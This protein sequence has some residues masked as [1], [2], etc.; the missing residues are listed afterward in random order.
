MKTAENA[1]TRAAFETPRVCVTDILMNESI[2][3]DC[4]YSEIRTP[5]YTEKNVLNGGTINSYSYYQVYSQILRF[6]EGLA[7]APTT[8]YLYFEPTTVCNNNAAWVSNGQYYK[9]YDVASVGQNPDRTL[10]SLYILEDGQ[11]SNLPVVSGGFIQAT[12]FNCDHLSLKC[13]F[14]EMVTIQNAHIGARMPH[15]LGGCNWSV[16][17]PAAQYNS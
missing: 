10:R 3:A 15:K 13:P 6:Y 8:H 2:A 5:F 1:T 7:F 9:T 12:S 17:H 14:N 4:C 11:I 16:P